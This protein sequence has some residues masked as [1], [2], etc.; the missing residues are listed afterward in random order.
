M[1]EPSVGCLNNC[2]TIGGSVITSIFA[3]G[4]PALPSAKPIISPMQI[5]GKTYA[6][7]RCLKFRHKEG[8]KF[9]GKILVLS[10]GYS[11]VWV[12]PHRSSKLCNW[13]G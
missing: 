13:S 4:F 5:T 7:H 3:V 10:G 11:R 9:L 6:T 12:D 2:V 8:T 1:V